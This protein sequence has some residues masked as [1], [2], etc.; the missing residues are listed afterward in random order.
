[1]RAGWKVLAVQELRERAEQ[2]LHDQAERRLRAL[3]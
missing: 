3:R 2:A 1:L